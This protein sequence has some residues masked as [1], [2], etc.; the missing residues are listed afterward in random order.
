MESREDVLERRALDARYR[1]ASIDALVA[2]ARV[3]D[4]RVA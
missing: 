2:L 3:T 1:V 4:S